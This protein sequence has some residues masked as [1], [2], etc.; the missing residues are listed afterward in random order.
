MKPPPALYDYV[1]IIDLETTGV[2]ANTHEIMEFGAAVLRDGE[3]LESFDELVATRKPPSL[4]VQKLTGIQPRD[5]KDARPLE[6][7]FP[8]FLEFIEREDALYIAH[9]ASFDR[10]FLQAVEGG[11]F[12]HRMLDTVGLSRI[13][14]PSLHSH[15]L[16]FLA[17]QLNLPQPSAHRALADC[18]TTAHLWNRLVREAMDLAPPL[19]KEINGLFSPLKVHPFR[20]F[21]RRVGEAQFAQ[22]FGK[23]ARSFR[24]LFTQHRELIETKQP[25]RDFDRDFHPLPPQQVTEVFED[26]GTLSTVLEAYQSRDGQID[27]AVEVTQALGQGQHLMVEAPTGIGKS[28]AYLIPSILFS[29]QENTPVILSTNTKNLQ[30]QLFEKDIPMVKEALGIDFKSALIKGRGNYLCLR[31]LFYLLDAA[32]RELDNDERP[33]IALLL[34]W[35]TQS[36]SGDIS[37]CVLSGR[38]N[39]STLWAKLR[40]LGDECT[41]RAC[42]QFHRCFLRRAR[43]LS[44]QADIVVANHALVFSELNMESAVLP[45]YRHIV[46]DEAH[47]LEAAATDHLSIEVS[48]MRIV[49]I[50]SRLHRRGRRNKRGTGLAAS[51]IAALESQACTAPDELA[52]IARRHSDNLLAAVTAASQQVHP[53]LSALAGTLTRGSGGSR[54]RFAAGKKRES[55][56]EPIETEKA[57][58]V[59]SLAAVMRSGEAVAEALLE[60]PPGGV[61][62]G[63][64]F[65]RELEAVVQWVREIISDIEFVL[66][67]SEV[68]YVYWVEQAHAKQGGAIAMA[69]PLSIAEIMHDQV[70]ARKASVIFSSATLSVRGTFDFLQGRLGID[71][72]DRDRL[73]TLCA[74][75][76]FDYDEQCMVLVPTFLPEPGGGNTE[77]YEKELS[78][79]MEQV[80]RRSNGRGMVLFTSYNM[81]K[82]CHA[83]L[84][85][86]MMGDGIRLL[87]QGMSGSREHITNLF[88]HDIHSVLLG[89]HSF[90]EGVDVAGESLSCLAIARL[91]FAVFTDP[92]VEARCEQLEA[93][94]KGAFMNYS[95]PSAVIR[96]KQG[97]GRLIRSRSDRGVIILADRRVVAKRYGKV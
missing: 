93:N 94:G 38:P 21:F 80:F 15:S 35:A 90:W 77:K 53:F 82:N 2:D 61:P 10:S 71:R 52:T 20:E 31:K 5:L 40:T 16:A 63:R 36:E 17:E 28:L 62:Y 12:Q 48:H 69:A 30:A 78:A 88:K 24:D 39:F 27:M 8:E 26:G 18:E 3:I 51:I 60:I 92:I 73:R 23:E 41:G 87:A 59:S 13:L 74:P 64:D 75:S 33:Q 66:A 84:E 44:L 46:F 42:K 50:L 7:V 79:L 45:E 22:N 1:V 89:T 34:N 70:Y 97:F 86:G 9:Q 55:L 6:E 96:F 58:L 11:G 67:G 19:L 72:I 25:E 14:L 68:N 85:K 76:P 54:Q 56:W 47:N 29:Q 83:A 95:V 37:E 91:P 65:Q 49:Q 32:D 57:N 43:A 81:L 4:Q